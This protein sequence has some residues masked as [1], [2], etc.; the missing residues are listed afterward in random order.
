MAAT[1]VAAAHPRPT[2]AHPRHAADPRR[3]EVVRINVGDVALTVDYYLTALAS[4]IEAGR[5]RWVRRSLRIPQT[6]GQTA[7]KS[8]VM[9]RDFVGRIARLFSTVL[10]SGNVAAEP[11]FSWGVSSRDPQR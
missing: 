8:E 3:R 4:D 2:A 6:L 10:D 11:A 9:V 7:A 1:V 5:R